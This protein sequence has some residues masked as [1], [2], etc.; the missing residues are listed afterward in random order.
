V[1]TAGANGTA[2]ITTYGAQI[3]NIHTNATSGTNI[4]LYLNASGATTAN[5]GLIVNS[6]FV[7]IGQTAPGYLLHVGSGSASGIVARFQNS[8]GTCDINPITSSLACS[9]DMN[10]KKNITAMNDDSAWSFNKNITP[11]SKDTLDKILALNPV[12]Y[13]WNI[14]PQIDPETGK[15]T[16]KHA[17]F[18][19]Q[20]V[21]QVFPDLVAEDPT[22]HLLSL[23]YGGLMPYTVQAIKEMNV[24]LKALP[25]FTDPT[26]AQNIA[27]FLTGIAQ[28]GE[29][30]VNL[31]TAKKV[32]TQQLCLG[33]AGN[34]VCVTA[35]QLRGLL[36]AQ[37]GGGVV[38]PIPTPDPTPAPT[39]KS[40]PTPT[41][42][43]TPA[44]A[45]TTAPAS[46]TPTPTP[47]PDPTPTPDPTPA[48]S[49]S[50]APTP[51][52]ASAPTPTPTPA[53]AAPT[54]PAA[55]PSN[56]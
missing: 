30:V 26:M 48:P 3:S 2:A 14:E 6:G 13:N 16:E 41:P 12:N 1:A 27:T 24:T 38:I 4:A 15:P 29:A 37:A 5:Y 23:N 34:T 54:T 19:A 28:R 11:A 8:A 40:T 25:T 9:S 43:S 56:P 21:R 7:G 32:N 44:P 33:D 17:G 42:A 35:D 52:P 51:T 18:I 55:T 45:D 53:P 39:P 20:E 46:S 36:Q 31:V 49:V 47:A 10:L 22:T 50:V